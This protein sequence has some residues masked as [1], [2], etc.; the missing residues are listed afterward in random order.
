M[1]V[2][3]E[4]ETNIKKAAKAAFFILKHCYNLYVD[5]TAEA[6]TFTVDGHD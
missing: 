4:R 1:G 2:Y 5:G 3:L 6:I